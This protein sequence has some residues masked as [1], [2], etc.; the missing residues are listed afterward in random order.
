MYRYVRLI[1]RTVQLYSCTMV[2]PTRDMLM[3]A[4]AVGRQDQASSQASTDTSLPG[5]RV[6]NG[7]PVRSGKEDGAA[8]RVDG[9]FRLCPIGNGSST[10]G[11][12][13]LLDLLLLRSLA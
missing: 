11:Q 6:Y 9:H 5:S 13:G 8:S 1:K 10:D 2:R 4:L 3:M 12:L 7:A